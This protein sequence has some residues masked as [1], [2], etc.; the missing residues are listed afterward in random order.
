MTTALHDPVDELTRR[1][2]LGAA[3]ALSVLAALPAC[4][5]GRDPADPTTTGWTY[6][7]SRG[8]DI[9]LTARPERVVA[10]A[11]AAAALIPLGI[12]PVGIYGSAPLPEDPTLTGLDLRGIASVG[13]TF[14]EINL[15][16]L[17]A[18]APDLVV[19]GYYPLEDQIGG[20]EP[21]D[22]RLLEKV[23]Q[24]APTVAITVTTSAVE[25][26]ESF[27]ALAER[28]GA[29]LQAPEVVAD[30]QAFD[31]AATR[32]REVVAA[33]PG[34]TVLAVSP[35]LNEGLYVANPEDFPE[36]IDYQRW[37]LKLV[38][39]DGVQARGYFALLSWELA[40]TYPA[41]LIYYDSRPASPTSEEIAASQPLWTTLPAIRAGQLV[42]WL[43][44]TYTS[45][46]RYTEHLDTLIAAIRAADADVVT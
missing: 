30:R 37:G 24:I 44:D 43:T 7:D 6:T 13:E 27:A 40:G 15:E 21:G 8:R 16:A 18:L 14:G 36:F 33:K 34:L 11:P 19:A 5:P 41:D 42:P 17:A 25:S 45:Y 26:I 35:S 22:T 31:D 28:L 1:R 38:Q 4:A 9:S 3:G 20:L 23:E 29:D 32:F 46:R 2:F 12:R 39:P 10:S